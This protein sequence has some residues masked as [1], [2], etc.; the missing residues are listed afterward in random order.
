MKSL[1]IQLSDRDFNKLGLDKTTLSF[2]ELIEI[3]GKKI[4]QRT[5]EKSIRLAE[6]YGLSKMTMEEINDE[7]K[8]YRNAKNNS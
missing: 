4:T 3:I 7:V 1:N 5:L 2:S 6:E 8:V